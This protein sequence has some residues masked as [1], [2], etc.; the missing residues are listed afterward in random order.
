[1][2]CFVDQKARCFQQIYCSAYVHLRHNNQ[3]EK[4]YSSTF[5]SHIYLS[6][7][8]YIFVFHYH[9]VFQNLK[10]P[11]EMQRIFFEE[12]RAHIKKNISE[13]ASHMH[14]VEHWEKRTMQNQPS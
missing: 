13:F 9:I 11:A 2:I 7:I 6:L 10:F 3:A 5:E 14:V 8:Y 1:M 4:H 12:Y